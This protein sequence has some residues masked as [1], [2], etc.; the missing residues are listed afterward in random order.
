MSSDDRLLA[1]LAE[2]TDG[3]VLFAA[4]LPGDAV[5][6]TPAHRHA[7]GQAFAA[8]RGLLT[9]G[10]D[11]GQW[12]VPAIHTVWIP[13]RHLHSLRSH[14]RFEGWSAYVAESACADLPPRPCTIRTSGLL[15]EAI[16]RVA[17][18]DGGPLDEAQARIAGVVLD[19]IRRLPHEPFGLPMPRDP[20]VLRVARAIADDLADNRRLSAWAEWA[21]VSPRTLTRRFAAETGFSVAEWRQ[22]A[23][24]M[25]ALEMLAVDTPVTTI[26][27]DLGY[28]NVSAFIAMFRRFFGVT[29]TK[30]FGGVVP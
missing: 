19:E 5:R 9:V 10:T 15:R 11:E 25:R 29:P 24:L 30:Y 6:V 13:P 14:G 12:V 27:L 1:A 20:R 26:A 22:R 18:W 2:S 3:P 28:E 21:A 17:S 16:G 8:T 7:R 23:R 4:E